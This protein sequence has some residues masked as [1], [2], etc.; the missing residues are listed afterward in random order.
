[1]ASSRRTFGVMAALAAACLIVESRTA[2]QSAPAQSAAAQS[3]AA[4]GAPDKVPL[5]H[6]VFKSVE[7]LKG[8]PVDTFFE[9]MGMFANAMG[10]DCTFCHVSKAYFDKTAFAEVTP[11]MRRARQMLTM[12]NDL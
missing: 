6:E 3:A 2:A 11:R 1:M 5:S 7:I 4:Q 12:M 9:T 8:I 10:N